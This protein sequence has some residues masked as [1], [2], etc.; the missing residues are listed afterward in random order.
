ME[1]ET[2]AHK[3]KVSKFE[4]EVHR[5]V[6]SNPEY[7]QLTSEIKAVH[8]KQITLHEKLEELQAKI[9]NTDNKYADLQEKKFKVKY[10]LEKEISSQLMKDPE[11][12]KLV[13][14]YDE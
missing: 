4:Q 14:V 5:I 7:V 12:A 13:D 3:V 6:L 2:T 11:I 10:K 8:D 9:Y 1:K